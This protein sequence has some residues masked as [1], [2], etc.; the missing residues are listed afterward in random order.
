MVVEPAATKVATPVADTVATPVFELEYV[1][2][3]VPAPPEA[4]LV[5]VASASGRLTGPTVAKVMVCGWGCAGGGAGGGLL[6]PPPPPQADRTTTS[7]QESHE[8][9]ERMRESSFGRSGVLIYVLPR[10]LS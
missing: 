8:A 10:T 6:P 3:P 2:V 5:Y 1:I 4:A 9:I 7:E